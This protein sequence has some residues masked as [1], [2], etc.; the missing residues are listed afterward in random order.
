MPDKLIVHDPRGFPPQ[1]TGKQ[2]APR[3][4]G[5]DGKTVFLIDCLFDNSDVCMEQLQHWFAAHLPTVRIKNIK[6][7]ESWV[8]DPE[9]RTA[10]VKE[11]DAAILGVGL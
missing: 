3:L 1:V 2:L 8:D 7:R 9:M 10:V 6:P 5:L 11:G 4:P